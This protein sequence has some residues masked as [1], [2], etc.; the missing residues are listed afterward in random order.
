MEGDGREEEKGY[1][2]V[3]DV[4]AAAAAAC[5]KVGP[6]RRPSRPS[7]RARTKSLE[8]KSLATKSHEKE[9]EDN[10]SAGHRSSEQPTRAIKIIQFLSAYASLLAVPFKG[11]GAYGHSR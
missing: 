5:A 2:V 8:K 3:V 6:A 4:A 9:E 1:F 11:G 7:A 10:L